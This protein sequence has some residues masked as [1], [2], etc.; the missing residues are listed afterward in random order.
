MKEVILEKDF[1]REHEEIRE[2]YMLCEIDNTYWNYEDDVLEMKFYDYY[3][4]AEYMQLKL[5]DKIMLADVTV[6]AK[7]IIF[8]EATLIKDEDGEYTFK[9][10]N[11][12]AGEGYITNYWYVYGTHTSIDD[13]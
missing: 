3:N 9:S 7:S 12:D 11:I 13:E 10:E 5:G 6:G 4:D 1:V 2:E 8:E